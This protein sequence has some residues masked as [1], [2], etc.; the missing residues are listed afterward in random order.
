MQ[1]TVTLGKEGHLVLPKEIRESLGLREGTRLRL[2]PFNGKFE[3]IPEADEVEIQIEDGF[4]V[5]SGGPPRE[6]DDIV[7]A[8]KADR[9]ERMDRILA[10]RRKK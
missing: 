5:I 9:E 6:E 2:E 8:I 4:P 1:F 10:H 3:A 7:K